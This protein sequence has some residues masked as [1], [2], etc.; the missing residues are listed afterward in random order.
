MFCKFPVIKKAI[1]N[2]E[3]SIKELEKE[4]G[5]SEEKIMKKLCGELEFD[6]IQDN[7]SSNKTYLNENEIGNKPHRIVSGDIIRVG[8]TKLR[9]EF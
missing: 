2:G 4:L 7:S 3:L 9:I 8:N 1:D 6:I 5:V